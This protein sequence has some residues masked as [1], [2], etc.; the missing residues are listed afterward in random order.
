MNQNVLE[1][2]VVC[3]P[4]HVSSPRWMFV[5]AL[6][7]CGWAL[8]LTPV[9]FAQTQPAKPVFLTERGFFNAPFALAITTATA[10]AA[11]YFSTDCS[12]PIPTKA[13]RYTSPFTVTN[14]LVVRARAFKDGF[15]PSDP[16][17]HTYLFLDDVIQQSPDGRPPPH[18]PATWGANAV[19]Y[20]MDP[21]VI[22]QYSRS[23]WREALTQ[24][25]LM[26]KKRWLESST[27]RRF[28]SHVWEMHTA[29]YFNEK[30]WT[31]GPDNFRCESAP[32]TSIDAWI[33]AHASTFRAAYVAGRHKAFES[34]I[35]VF[36]ELL[37]A[38][39]PA[40]LEPYRARLD[41]VLA[42]MDSIAALNVPKR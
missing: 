38:Q 18:F 39:P 17:T 13:I 5:V 3:A 32:S 7:G 11:I 9:A 27:D 31:G 26:V 42:L 35:R 8:A 29:D 10:D 24:M 16:E 19:D 15:L 4:F 23:E 37:V 41:Q 6:L 33:N 40:R 12:D 34:Q 30:P 14:T 28:V 36:R 22:A 25:D 20:G 1:S 21:N 2:N